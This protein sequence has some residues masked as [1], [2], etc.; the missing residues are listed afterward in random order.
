MCAMAGRAPTTT[1]CA[2]TSTRSS[3]AA[4]SCFTTTEAAARRVWRLPSTYNFDQ[5]A[6]DVEALRRSR[7]DDRIVVV[8][9]SMGADVALRLAIRHPKGL[10]G[11]VL[12][13]GAPGISIPETLRAMS[14]G[15]IGRATG[16]GLVYLVRWIWRAE[17]ER[18][19]LA[20]YAIWRATFESRPEVQQQLDGRAVLRRNDNASM[21]ERAGFDRGVWSRI[22]ELQV[23]VLL[24]YGSRDAGAVAAGRRFRTTTPDAEE[25]VIADAGHHPLFESPMALAAVADFLARTTATT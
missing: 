15:A 23:P 5:L 22:A 17:S 10:A 13:G 20:R 4:H 9:H 16:R 18:R 24:V 7:G 3:I 14:P 11:A 2:A 12:I 6:D 8:G 21:L 25:V 19:Q 1:T